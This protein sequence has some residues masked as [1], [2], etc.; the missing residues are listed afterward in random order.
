MYI[1]TIIKERYYG[2]ENFRGKTKIDHS[3]YRHEG[4]KLLSVPD[5]Q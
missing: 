5:G 2:A 4:R 3:L 1:H